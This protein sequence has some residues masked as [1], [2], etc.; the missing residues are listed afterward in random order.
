MPGKTLLT[1]TALVLCVS[2]A[3]AAQKVNQPS[4]RIPLWNNRLGLPL[5]LD[6]GIPRQS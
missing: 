6:H 4:N 1:T 3:F 2:A 5:H